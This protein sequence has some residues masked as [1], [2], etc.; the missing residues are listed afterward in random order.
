MRLLLDT[1]AFF[2]GEG[3]EGA[4]EVIAACGSQDVE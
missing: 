2:V 4:Q 3:G 1:S